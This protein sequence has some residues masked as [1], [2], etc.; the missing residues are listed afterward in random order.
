MN[1]IWPYFLWI[2]I[3]I[4]YN[5]LMCWASIKYGHQNFMG[6]YLAMVLFSTI[7][8]WSLASYFSTNIIFDGLVFDTTLVLTSPIIFWA[9]NQGQNFTIISWIGV[10]LT[11]LGL[12]TV[13][14]SIPH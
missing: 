9:L 3:T 1:K 14:W 8:T 10:V 2:P 6:M 11:V 4:I 12:L 7:P 5:Y 13:R